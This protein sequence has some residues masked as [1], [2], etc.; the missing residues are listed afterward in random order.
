MEKRGIEGTVSPVS[1]KDTASSYQSK[2][3]V[4]L[5]SRE[6]IESQ[7]TFEERGYE[8]VPSDADNAFS[9]I[10]QGGIDVVVTYFRSSRH[11]SYPSGIH[12]GQ[13]TKAKHPQIPVVFLTETHSR[14]VESIVAAK[15]LADYVATIPIYSEAPELVDKVSE[16]LGF[17]EP[18]QEPATAADANSQDILLI[19]NS[20]YRKGLEELLGDRTYQVAENLIDGY[21]GLVITDNPWIAEESGNFI[22]VEHPRKI[23]GERLE[24]QF[25]DSYV[26]D[27]TNNAFPEQFSSALEAILS[28]K[29]QQKRILVVDDNKNQLR[30]YKQDIG[31]AL[32][33]KGLNDYGIT[34]LFSPE[35]VPHELEKG[36]VAVVVLDYRYDEVK[37]KQNGLQVLE[38]MKK[39]EEY[40]Q[41][42]VIFHTAMDP[43]MLPIAQQLGAYAALR[44]SSDTTG[45]INTVLEALGYQQQQQAGQS[46]TPFSDGAEDR[47]VEELK[48]L[49][50][51]ET[52][53]DKFLTEFNRSQEELR[54]GKGL[55]VDD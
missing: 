4:L 35:D 29:H 50:K 14:V 23:I 22:L 20:L 52:T 7:K 28:P 12:I 41:I 1:E 26:L 48:S 13:V 10:E 25:P 3:R 46:T 19:V 16:L 9:I 47:N 49:K 30:L 38:E 5:V 15:N 51:S 2:P 55:F 27:L 34:M 32:E 17:N 33:E 6:P 40:A 44:K 18:I 37:S 43:K 8:V 39:S 54:V 11:D 42:P 24:S 21:K 36:D 31:D 45:L 53:P